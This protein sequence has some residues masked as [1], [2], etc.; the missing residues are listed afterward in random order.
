MKKR[1]SITLF[2]YILQALITNN[3]TQNSNKKETVLVNEL[4]LFILTRDLSMMIRTQL[5]Y[6]LELRLEVPARLQHW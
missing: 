3:L 5:F 1:S 6:D 4:L 2:E